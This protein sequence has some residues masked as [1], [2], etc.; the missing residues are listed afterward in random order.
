MGELV[1]CK[2]CNHKVSKTAAQCPNC[3]EVSPGR[4]IKEDA[5]FAMKMGGGCLYFIFGM[6]VLMGIGA[7]VFQ[8]KYGWLSL[9]LI[10]FFPYLIKALK[11]AFKNKD[12][13]SVKKRKPMKKSTVVIIR[14]SVSIVGIFGGF[15]I[16]MLT[17]SK[18]SPSVVS[19]IGIL[20]AFIL[21]TIGLLNFGLLILEYIFIIIRKSVQ[22]MKE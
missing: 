9:L 1:N 22:A 10:P 11:K 4:D 20:V 6:P 18:S 8:T 7:L 21:G 17:N 14:L 15:L 12:I 5:I 3:G 16:G 19:D 2:I 13:K